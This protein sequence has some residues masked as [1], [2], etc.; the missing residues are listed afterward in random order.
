MASPAGMCLPGYGHGTQWRNAARTR[1]L[2]DAGTPRPAGDVCRESRRCHCRKC[3]QG[4]AAVIIDADEWGDKQRT[5]QEGVSYALTCEYRRRAD[6][7]EHSS[8]RS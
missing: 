8:A 3:S 2:Y 6:A 1:T 4:E 7:T 5:F